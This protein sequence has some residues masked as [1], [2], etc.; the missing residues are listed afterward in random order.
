MAKRY[1]DKNDIDNYLYYK[2][3]SEPELDLD[4]DIFLASKED[5]SLGS[6]V[7]EYVPPLSRRHSSDD[8]DS[9]MNVHDSHQAPITS[10]STTL[11]NS[12]VLSPT[13]SSSPNDDWTDTPDPNSLHFTFEE[14]I[15]MN[16][17]VSSVEDFVDLFLPEEFLQML[18]K[19]TNMYASQEINKNGPLRRSS[20]MKIW[21]PT[22]VGEM[23]VYLG[24]FLRM[25]SFTL[26]S[27]DLYW[28][29]DVLYE[30]TLWSSVMS[31][32]R[33]QLLRHFFHF[34]DNSVE[35]DD[36]LYK[37]RP[38]LNHFNGSMKRIYVPEKNICIDKSMML[39]GGRLLFHQ[40]IKNKKHKCGIKL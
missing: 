24:L 5:I 9:N 7:D 25:G 28:S 34:A 33:F 12:T 20:R 11:P 29:K 18:V 39:W 13:S 32:N 10:S 21:K 26:P 31:R 2:D 36:R 17:D 3:D 22:N 23:K 15:G 27:V 16:T 14:D 4:D 6:D 19:Q 35:S 38:I 8:D 30:S 1:L 37:F 40:Y